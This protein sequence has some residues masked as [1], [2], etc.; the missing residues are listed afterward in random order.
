MRR[1]ILNVVEQPRWEGDPLG[2][3]DWVAAFERH[4]RFTIG[5]EEELMLLDP[6]TLDLAPVA[7]DLLP[8]VGDPH[9]STELNAAQLEII[10][11]V[12]GT[13]TEACLELSRLRRQL[14]ETLAGRYR[15]LACGT[16]P[17][18]TRRAEI[19]DAQHYRNIARD[20]EFATR[21]LACGL[22]VHVA[23]PGADRALAVFNALRSYLPE[24]AALSA[25]SVFSEGADTG[26]ASVRPKFNEAFPR[27][28]VP[29]AFQSWDELVEFV[30]WGRRGGLF[31]DASQLWWE[32]RPHPLHGTIEI[33]VADTQTRVADATAVV[34][35]IQA[36]VMD[37][38][39]RYQQGQV[40]PVHK[41]YRISENAWRA[42]RDGVSGW[43]VDL[44]TGE[45]VSTRERLSRLIDR[46]EPQAASADAEEQLRDARLLIAGNGSDRQRYV[47]EQ[48]G[49]K[50]LTQWL[51]DQT[52]SSADDG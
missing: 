39:S 18:S 21:N 16:H 40:L 27:S 41:S 2:V 7:P 11:P 28:G 17:F 33:R 51:S 38:C 46:L 12:C 30:R 52:E 34:A 45:R 24:L 29:P 23:V 32:M 50:G 22:H 13:A 44:D 1:P 8:L 5:V 3:E 25:N 15:A 14:H 10:T 43:M 37:L 35:L 48:L 9:F 19:T 49:S 6:V 4:S 42:S 36:L 26:L 47:Y 31:P 20:Y